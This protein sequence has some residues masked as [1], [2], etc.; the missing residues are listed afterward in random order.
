MQGPHQG[1]ALVQREIA[2][3]ACAATRDLI[4]RVEPLDPDSLGDF[5]SMNTT[6]VGSPSSCTKPSNNAQMTCKYRFALYNAFQ[7][8]V[9]VTSKKYL[10]H[11]ENNCRSL[12]K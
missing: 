2:G 12:L 5:D 11:L 4:A 3:G 1:E 6:A 7:F 10:S 9:V 8:K